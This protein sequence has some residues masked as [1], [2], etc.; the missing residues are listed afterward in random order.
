MWNN[1]GVSDQIVFLS[2]IAFTFVLMAL[3]SCTNKSADT[4]IQQISNATSSDVTSSDK[5]LHDSV[6]VPLYWENTT[7]KHDERI[8]WSD[9]LI[10]EIDKNF[11][12][13]DSPTDVIKFCPKFNSLKKDQKLKAV[14]EFFVSIALYESGFNPDSSSVDVGTQS[15]KGSW[16][17]GLFQ[18]SGNDSSAK[19]F[20]ADYLLLKN[21]ITN[22]KVA[23]EQMRRQLASEK[24]YI[25]PNSNK[26]RYWAT[27]LDGNKY[28]KLTD[29]VNLIKKNQP[30]CF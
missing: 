11:S 24:L 20:K 2:M 6:R 15:D 17:V 12:V 27:I 21:P 18:M 8:V 10:S 29:I 7:S 19:V 23:V 14:G 5:S 22:I 16:S 13:F 25:L 30:L 3:A 4:K 28:S 9:T 26:M 1:K